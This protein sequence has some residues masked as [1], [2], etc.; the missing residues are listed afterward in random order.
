[1]YYD[2]KIKPSQFKMG[3]QVLL[4]NSRKLT[5]KGGKLNLLWSGPY[6]IQEVLK[7]GCYRLN[8]QSV[9][10]NGC[11][12]KEY[13]FKHETN[14]DTDQRSS[15]MAYTGEKKMKGNNSTKYGRNDY[16]SRKHKD[17]NNSEKNVV[18]N[19]KSN[20]TDSHIL[21]NEPSSPKKDEDQNYGFCSEKVNAT[22]SAGKREKEPEMT[23]KSHLE[24]SKL[25]W[26]IGG[27]NN[28]K[29][30][31]I[32]SP[33]K[34]KTS[35][36]DGDEH[37]ANYAE[38]RIVFRLPSENWQKKKSR[39]CGLKVKNYHKTVPT[40]QVSINARPAKHAQMRGD[41]SIDYIFGFRSILPL[42]FEEF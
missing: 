15:S 11:R 4:H 36:G 41:G 3:D 37:E 17:V 16:I 33:K 1:M 19:D 22:R 20:V 2:S 7:L 35:R 24:D 29:D 26:K 32:L 28:P 42:L 10:V 30:E 27:Q 5:R 40:R 34:R 31:T 39:F 9:A 38:T 13:K 18:S 23:I 25:R 8:G 21:P 12:L 14:Q 6:T